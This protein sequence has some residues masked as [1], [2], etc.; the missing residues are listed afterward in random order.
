MPSTCNGTQRFQQKALCEEAPHRRG[1][2]SILGIAPA[3]RE[4]K[5]I[6]SSTRLTRPEDIQ[7]VSRNSTFL[8]EINVPG[9][10]SPWRSSASIRQPAQAIIPTE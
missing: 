4:E 5:P 8:A 7:Y 9:A 6:L 2:A 1:R 3:V 10:D